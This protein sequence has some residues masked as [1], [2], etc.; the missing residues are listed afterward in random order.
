MFVF[1]HFMKKNKQMISVD[2]ARR[3]IT[4]FKHPTATNAIETRNLGQCMN[5]AT[6]DADVRAITFG[7]PGKAGIWT[8]SSDP[9]V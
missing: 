2:Q 8:W 9:Y 3:P 4:I 7:F 6:G 1:F 5:D